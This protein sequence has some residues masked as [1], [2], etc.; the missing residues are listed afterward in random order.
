[1][2]PTVRDFPPPAGPPPI[3]PRLTRR[4]VQPAKKHKTAS[5]SLSDPNAPQTASGG[6]LWGGYATG[7]VGTRPILRLPALIQPAGSGTNQFAITT[8]LHPSDSR[9]APRPPAT[10]WPLPVGAPFRRAHA[11][12]FVVFG[13]RKPVYRCRSEA[14]ARQAALSASWISPGRS[15]PLPACPAQGRAGRLVPSSPFHR[16]G[17]GRRAT[18]PGP[19]HQG[20][21]ALRGCAARQCRPPT[22]GAACT[23][24]PT[25]ASSVPGR[26]ASGA[27]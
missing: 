1:M 21:T 20:P 27:P 13:D 25:S 18:Q 3:G 5:R 8:T 2:A 4:G 10:R 17:S 15:P 9:S 14:G 23:R 16:T 19:R 11:C 22:G 26:T 24:G 12:R 7:M 6:Q